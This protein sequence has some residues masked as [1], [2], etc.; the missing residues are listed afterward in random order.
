M[1]LLGIN[2]PSLQQAFT[3]YPLSARYHVEC[4]AYNDKPY[5]TQT[6]SGTTH[7]RYPRLPHVGDFGS[8]ANT[9]KLTSTDRRHIWLGSSNR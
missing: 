9:G 1:D 3:G 2:L 4:W 6:T 5:R 8:Q 7:L